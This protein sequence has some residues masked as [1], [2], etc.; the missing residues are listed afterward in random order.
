MFMRAGMT[1]LDLGKVER[2][3]MWAEINASLFFETDFN[4]EY[5]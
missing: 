1:G 2:P 4:I 5:F 3:E